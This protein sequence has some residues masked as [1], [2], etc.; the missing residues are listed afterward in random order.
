MAVNTY[1]LGQDEVPDIYVP[2]ANLST[3]DDG[4]GIFRYSISGDTN[5]IFHV[6][7]DTLFLK[8]VPPLGTHNIKVVLNDPLNRFSSIDNT[9]SLTVA[10]HYCTQ[11]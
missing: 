11:E 4:C 8:K 3:S 7:D 1:F 10:A 9:F 6:K 2:V 5:G